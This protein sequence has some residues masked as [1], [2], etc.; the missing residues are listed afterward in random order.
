MTEQEPSNQNADHVDDEGVEYEEVAGDEI[1]DPFDP[2]KIKVSTTPLTID[3]VLSRIKHDELKL[4]PDFQRDAGL[5]TQQAQSRLIESILIRIPI[6]AFYVDATDEDQWLVV[7][8]LQ[9][10]TTLNSFVLKK[11]LKLHGMEFLT[12]LN[13]LGFDE[14]QT[15]YQRRILETQVTVYKIEQGTPPNVKFNIFKRIN[16]G[17][18]PLSPQEIR[19]ALNQ[20]PITQFLS[21]LANTNEFLKATD[22]GVK[23]KRMTARELA[24]RYLAFSLT[25]YTEYS[26][27]LDA[28]LNQAMA[29][30]NKSEKIYG[31]LE[32]KFIT[33]MKRAVDVFGDDA[34]RKRYYPQVARSSVN[35]ALFEAWSV[36]LS[37]IS[38]K[39][40]EGLKSRRDLLKEK[41]IE[42]MN[43]RDFN[44]SI[45]Q[46]TGDKKKVQVRFSYINRI[47][48][49]TLA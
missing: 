34:F 12:L 48:Q 23:D 13:G 18:L 41:F 30:L 43:T 21:K 8:G 17:G 37:Q 36:N 46:G 25:P 4:N 44:E 16:T 32:N 47:I 11:D 3:L 24:L 10:L 5:W 15:R 6:P 29:N 2:T 27:D 1:T 14:L 49:E 9:R 7:D 22:Y 45:S 26:G 28:F 39:D 35:K 19:N 33:A 20:G 40:F 31:R 38:E 42:L